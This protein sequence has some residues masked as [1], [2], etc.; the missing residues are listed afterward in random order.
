M[1]K[2]FFL[3]FISLL[4][5]A[6]TPSNLPIILIDTEG[7]TIVDEP[8]VMANMK[9]INGTSGVLNTVN[10]KAEIETNIGIEFRGSS[11]QSFP[12]KPYGIESW[13]ANGE[14]VS[15][16]P[17]G[18]PKESDWILFASYNEKSLMHN[19]LALK[20]G[21]GMGMYASRTKYVELYMNGKYEG[22][23]VFMEKLK[24]DKGRVDIAKL[25]PDEESG[26]DLT[27]GYIIKI[28]KGT[29][30]NIG[31]WKSK[32]SNQ[33]E[34]FKPTEFFYEYPKDISTIQKNYIKDYVSSFED[35]LM[36]KN[37]TDTLEGYQKYID[38]KTFVKMT[39][40]NEVTK[41]VDGYRISTFLY[42]DK[43]GKLKMGPPWDY[44]ISFGNANYCNGNSPEGFSYNF[45]VYCKED[46]WQV[47]FWWN[48][49][50]G[51][52]N[53]IREFRKEYE[54]LRRNG[55]L[56]EKELLGLIEGMTTEI[57]DAQKKNF[58]RWPILGTYIWPQPEPIATSWEGEVNELKTWLGKRLIW[59]D[60]NIPKE[61]TVLATEKEQTFEVLAY[62]NPFLE[63]L[64]L[65][66]NAKESGEAHISMSDLLGKEILNQ[67]YQIQK[68][69]NQLNLEFPEHQSTQTL[70]LLKVEIDGKVIIQKV[71]RN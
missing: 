55:V 41:N 23:Y 1:K 67:S 45:N 20:I 63:K 54:D 14:D 24:R 11:S 66:I 18:W 60:N 64:S 44:D 6:Q 38:M 5:F 51:D 39:I 34:F 35:A 27:G 40:L 33:N 42:K 30:T 7:R 21:Q 10:D 58:L 59:L 49:F 4:G 25:D 29:G 69:R 8:K 22:V 28:D 3:L 26:E 47:P 57:K 32:Y 56:Q 50:L 19:V 65:E 62:P 13:D 15:I 36:S 2:T 70:K 46:N 68:G 43:N 9:I 71:L 17:F 48:R 37:Y 16:E 61:L 31:G 12:K 52:V 53:F